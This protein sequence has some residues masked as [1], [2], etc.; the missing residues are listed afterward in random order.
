MH[1]TT[2]DGHG[3]AMGMSKAQMI[4]KEKNETPAEEAAESPAYEKKEK[5]MGLEMKKD[6]KGY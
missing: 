3:Y 1:K 4:K 6:K 5:K 2:K